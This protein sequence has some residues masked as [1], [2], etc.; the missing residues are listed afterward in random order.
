MCRELL[1]RTEIDEEDWLAS[2]ENL[3]KTVDERYETFLTECHDRSKALAIL[4]IVIGSMRPLRLDELC[5]ALPIYLANREG[6][7]TNDL[8]PLREEAT[9]KAVQDLCGFFLTVFPAPD[10]R[11]LPFHHTVIEFLIQSDDDDDNAEQGSTVKWRNSLN[12]RK[13]HR[14]LAEICMR[15][16][17]SIELKPKS[18]SSSDSLAHGGIKL[19]RLQETVKRLDSTKSGIANFLDYASS[20]WADHFRL[21]E[22]ESNDPL[23]DLARE[24]CKVDSD[25]YSVWFKIYWWRITGRGNKTG[26]F[27]D[28]GVATFLGLRTL[29]RRMLCDGADVDGDCGEFGFPLYVA[30]W[31]GNKEMVQLLLEERADINQVNGSNGNALYAALTNR[32]NDVVFLLLEAGAQVNQRGGIYGTVLTSAAVKGDEEVVEALLAKNAD[33]GATCTTKEAYFPDALSAALWQNHESIVRKLLDRGAQIAHHDYGSALHAACFNNQE[34]LIRLFLERNPGIINMRGGE[35]GYPLQ[36][37]AWRGSA[38]IVEMLLKHGAKI[39]AQGGYFGTALQAASYRGSEDIVRLLLKE[40][41]KQL[42]GGEFFCPT[43]AAAANDKLHIKAILDA[44]R[45]QATV[46]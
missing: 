11:V 14:T 18:E 34:G 44:H 3:P 40:G 4:G 7:P 22:F 28:L 13:C 19:N 2:V 37:A 45:E 15:A 43:M 39:D 1:T 10:S 42:D 26:R 12:Q 35:L 31:M 30:A 27:T 6:K 5:V 24:L 33:I 41:A 38:A 23:V 36:A 20:F 25:C 17:I 16:L 21:A 8:K 9:K 46:E 29:V 32:K